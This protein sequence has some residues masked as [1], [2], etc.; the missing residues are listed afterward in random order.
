MGDPIDES[1]AHV[2]LMPGTKAVDQFHLIE[3]TIANELKNG[4]LDAIV[5]VSGGFR[6]D[7]ASSEDLFSNLQL[8]YAS[9]VESS[10]V[11]MRLASGYLS[12]G[13]LLIL[14]GA[15]GAANGTPWAV[16]YGAMKA[17]V[18]HM[19]KSLSQRG[20]GMPKDSITIGI[21][22]V[23]LDT[24]ANRKDMPDA[25]FRDW[26]PL[27]ELADKIVGWAEKR[28]SA[29]SGSIYRVKTTKEETRYSVL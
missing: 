19:V 5:N 24:P 13:G 4:K 7:S 26:T 12:E 10:A 15:A 8:M 3:K 29:Q 25:D 28:E 23:M 17:A 6:L 2:R 22:P 11:A 21:A 27:T 20:S 18:H 9:S 16:S 14:P 1:S